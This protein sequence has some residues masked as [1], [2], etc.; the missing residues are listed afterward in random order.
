MIREP[1]PQTLARYGFSLEEWRAGVDAQGGVC[2]ICKQE[3]P[4]VFDHDHVRGWFDMPPEK[5]KLFVR[6]WLCSYD[7][8]R[9]LPRGATPEKLRNAASY[10]EAYLKRR[11]R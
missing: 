10:L 1:S 6:G 9:F 7:N 3:K 11:P 2:A 4:L 8:W 5:R